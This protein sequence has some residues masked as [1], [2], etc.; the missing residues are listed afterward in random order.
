MCDVIVMCHMRMV[1]IST[2]IQKSNFSKAKI[3]CF[4]MAMSQM[5]T[6]TSCFSKQW[7]VS[8]NKNLYVLTKL[9]D[10]TTKYVKLGGVEEASWS[11]RLV[12]DE[13]KVTH[14]GL[15]IIVTAPP[16][17]GVSQDFDNMQGQD[18]AYAVNEANFVDIAKARPEVGTIKCDQN[19]VDNFRKRRQHKY[20]N[21]KW[22]KEW[23]KTEVNCTF[24][25]VSVEMDKDEDDDDDAEV[26]V[27]ATQTMPAQFGGACSSTASTSAG[28]TASNTPSGNLKYEYIFKLYYMM[29][30]FN[31]TYNMFRQK[32]CK[33]NGKSF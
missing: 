20:K 11:R 30:N 12:T 33:K 28:N 14:A 26:L 23:C 8:V 4:S 9:Q 19:L 17:G 31:Y 21:G 22:L 3:S 27:P 18:K 16:P 13:N 24:D 32:N 29:F 6:N 1:K 2:I 10:L 15:R 25:G 7:G 5:I